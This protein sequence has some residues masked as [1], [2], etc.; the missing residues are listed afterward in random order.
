M[1]FDRAMC[2]SDFPNATGERLMPGRLAMG[3][4]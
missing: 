2:V 4:V 1:F 3:N